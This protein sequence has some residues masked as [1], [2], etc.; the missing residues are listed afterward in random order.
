MV[1]EHKDWLYMAFA[2]SVAV[3]ISGVSGWLEVA[4]TLT[5]KKAKK[6]K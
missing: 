2:T 1:D 4:V 5:E 6:T 3:M